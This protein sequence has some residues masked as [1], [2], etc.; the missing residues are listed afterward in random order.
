MHNDAA[1]ARCIIN[2]QTQESGPHHKAIATNGTLA[3]SLGR[4]SGRWSGS[5]PKPVALWRQSPGYLHLIFMRDHIAGVHRIRKY[6]V[7]AKQKI[8]VK[9]EKIKA[10][11]IHSGV[12]E[13]L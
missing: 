2:L 13:G 10:N 4:G 7:K 6:K 3:L 8:H 9:H 5:S 12:R 1:H 11:D